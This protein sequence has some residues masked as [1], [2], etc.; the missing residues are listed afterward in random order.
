MFVFYHLDD[1]ILLHRL[2]VLGRIAATGVSLL[3]PALKEADY[4]PVYWQQ[5]KEIAAK[6]IITIKEQEMPIGFI[7]QHQPTFR[8][9]GRSLLM[10]LHF[11]L[12]EQA[13]MVVNEDDLF[14]QQLC[15]AL[16]VPVYSLEDFNTAT[17]NNKMYFEFM[18]EI[19]KEQTSR[20]N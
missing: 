4:S 12:A 18:A 5:V 10:L 3:V 1:L 9:A 8:Y 6:G 7:H 11:C 14:V 13:I 17:I 2:Q 19:K 16:K 20:L 15:G